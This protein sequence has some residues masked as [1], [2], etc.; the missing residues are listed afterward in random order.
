[1]HNDVADNGDKTLNNN[2]ILTMVKRKWAS[3]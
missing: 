3:R 1:M 2:N